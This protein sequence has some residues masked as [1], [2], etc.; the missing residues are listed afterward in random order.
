MKIDLTL[1]HVLIRRKCFLLN[2]FISS[3]VGW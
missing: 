2:N 3:F 1:K